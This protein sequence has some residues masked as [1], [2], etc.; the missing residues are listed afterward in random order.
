[1]GALRFIAVHQQIPTAAGLTGGHMFW[2]GVLVGALVGAIF[3]R[4]V[5]FVVAAVAFVAAG[6][7]QTSGY[8]ASLAVLPYLI[9]GGIALAAG[10][11]FGRI[12]GLRHLGESDFQTRRAAI[13]R[14]SRF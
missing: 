12:R 6:F 14:I 3:A 7:L 4:W 1:M 8:H 9:V 13:R 5:A 11:F 10:L 2:S